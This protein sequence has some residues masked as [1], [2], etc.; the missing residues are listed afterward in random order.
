M[1]M[2]RAHGA[3]KELGCPGEAE[4]ATNACAATFRKLNT[5]SGSLPVPSGSIGALFS[6]V[7]GIGVGTKLMD[8]VMGAARAQGAKR[9]WL[10]TTNGDTPKTVH[11]GGFE[12]VRRL[13]G[14]VPDKGNDGIPIEHEFEFEMIF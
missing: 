2:H 10:V 12:A 9:L 7:Q 1:A 3:R 8:A 13:K 14:G 11:F 6:L 5:R 4:P